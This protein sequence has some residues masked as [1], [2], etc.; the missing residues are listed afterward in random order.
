MAAFLTFLIVVIIFG[1]LFMNEIEKSKKNNTYNKYKAQ[2]AEEK[3]KENRYE[4]R[5]KKLYNKEETSQ[6]I[7][8]LKQMNKQ[9]DN[10]SAARKTENETIHE[11]EIIKKSSYQVNKEKGD[12]Y[13]K[14]IAD[15]YKEQGYTI[16]EHGQDNG[17]KDKGIDVI[18]K[19][20]KELLLIQCKNWNENNKLTHSEIKEIRMNMIDFL[21]KHEMY[22]NL[23]KVTKKIITPYYILDRSAEYYLKE[24]NYDIN[25]KVIPI[26]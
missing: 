3:L 17:R 2:K 24:I 25:Y 5:I 1:K 12:M 18:A 8:K 26:T 22:D 23:C 14:Y 9:R 6:V 19:K 7:E 13:E 10:Y 4:N 21:S 11:S 15:Y 16:A 20:E